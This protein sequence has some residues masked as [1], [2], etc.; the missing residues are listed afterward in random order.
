MRTW[1]KTVSCKCHSTKAAVAVV[2][3]RTCG[4]DEHDTLLPLHVCSHVRFHAHELQMGE[5]MSRGGLLQLLRR[6]MAV[7]TPTCAHELRHS[8]QCG[9]EALCVPSA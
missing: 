4:V 1:R 9:C 7:S 5:G 6:L 8:G 2:A 3:Q